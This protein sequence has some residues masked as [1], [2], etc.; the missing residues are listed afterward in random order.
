M[1][2]KIYISPE[3]VRIHLEVSFLILAA[4]Q[5]PWADAKQNIPFEPA[6][7]DNDNP[8]DRVGSGDNAKGLWDD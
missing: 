7:M 1:N 6:A 2:K 4:T 8:W 5:S 3:T